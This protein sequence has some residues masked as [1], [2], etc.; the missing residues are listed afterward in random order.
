MDRPARRPASLVSWVLPL[1]C[2]VSAS[3]AVP[4]WYAEARETREARKPERIRDHIADRMGALETEGEA[5]L[6]GEKVEFR[7]DLAEFYRRRD[8]QPAWI[9]FGRHALPAA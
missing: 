4:R 9:V 1:F 6:A 8:H 7:K 3:Q 2:F 5:V